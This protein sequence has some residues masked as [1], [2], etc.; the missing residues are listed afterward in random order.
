MRVL[1]DHTYDEL[2][3]LCRLLTETLDFIPLRQR[4]G[5]L[6]DIEDTVR[7]LCQHVER[8]D[9]YMKDGR[10]PTMWSKRGSV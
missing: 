4:I 2:M 7:R 10:A 6:D 9:G 5:S 1:E 8:L 3:R